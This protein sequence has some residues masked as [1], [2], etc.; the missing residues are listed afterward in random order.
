MHY[1]DN[2]SAQGTNEIQSYPLGLLIAYTTGF[3][4]ILVN[5][6]DACVVRSVCIPNMIPQHCVL[7]I[8]GFRQS[9]VN[10]MVLHTV[11]AYRYHHK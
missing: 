7:R 10:I 1:K 4:S 2:I 8:V 5:E 6:S 3:S 11:N 9:V